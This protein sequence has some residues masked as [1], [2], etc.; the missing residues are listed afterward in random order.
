MAIPDLPVAPSTIARKR[1]WWASVWFW[2]LLGAATGG[3][4]FTWTQRAALR[5]GALAA[6][7]AGQELAKA[8]RER[9]P[10]AKAVGEE[11]LQAAK[12]FGEEY[13]PQQLPERDESLPSQ[14]SAAR[15]AAPKDP[16]RDFNQIPREARVQ[17]TQRA[18]HMARE[19]RGGLKDSGQV[20][21][22]RQLMG[23]PVLLHKHKVSF[24]ITDL[25]RG[26]KYSAYFAAFFGVLGYL[27]F[28][29]TQTHGRTF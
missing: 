5:R 9:L 16:T 20:Q 18:R 15:L 2:M 21:E 19:L 4:F 26:I 11:L 28:R 1:P 23:A 10:A 24:W 14:P 8:A 13:L 25:G 29:T 12:D 17:R 3:S 22:T 27:L 7:E 6:P